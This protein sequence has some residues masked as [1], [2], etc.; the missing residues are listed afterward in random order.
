[1]GQ[2]AFVTPPTPRKIVKGP[3]PSPLTPPVKSGAELSQVMKGF[4]DYENRLCQ[5]MKN[6]GSGTNIVDAVTNHLANI[7]QF[8]QSLISNIVGGGPTA[9]A[10]PTQVPAYQKV[11]YNPQDWSKVPAYQKAPYGSNIPAGL[12]APQDWSQVPNWQKA[13]YAPAAPT[14]DEIVQ[15]WMDNLNNRWR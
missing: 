12:T 5:A 10:A 1:M 4:A 8:Y 15:Q 9:Q 3:P 2:N 14:Q 7:H 13:P 6:T 11:P